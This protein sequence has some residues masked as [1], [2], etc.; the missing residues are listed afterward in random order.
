MENEGVWEEVRGEVQP[1]EAGIFFSKMNDQ[2]VVNIIEEG[3]S[4][5]FFMGTQIRNIGQHFALPDF[6]SPDFSQKWTREICR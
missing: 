5:P 3:G 2:K 6:I 1:W 4:E